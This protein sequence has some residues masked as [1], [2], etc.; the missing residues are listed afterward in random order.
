MF[1]INQGFSGSLGIESELRIIERTVIFELN[2]VGAAEDIRMGKWA[3][4]H[5]G[6]CLFRYFSLQTGVSFATIHA[7]YKV[8]M[9]NLLQMEL[10]DEETER[11]LDEV[12]LLCITR[13]LLST[14]QV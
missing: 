14:K 8:Q 5:V 1:A 10:R 4:P 7:A 13:A 6:K 3:V 9:K 12:R 2:M 11:K